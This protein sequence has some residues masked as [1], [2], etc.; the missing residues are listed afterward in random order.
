ML[1]EKHMDS[2]GPEDAET[3][4]R[5]RTQS[6]HV[7]RLGRV[8]TSGEYGSSWYLNKLL[9]GVQSMYVRTPYICM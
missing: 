4:P 9:Y 2:L 6:A 1:D 8:G 3:L 5:S 7:R